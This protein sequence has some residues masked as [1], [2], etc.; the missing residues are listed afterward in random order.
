MSVLR[1][2]PVVAVA[3]LFAASLVQASPKTNLPRPSN[4]FLDPKDDPYNP[5][6]YIASNVLT[7]VA[8]SLIMFVALTET[9]M[10]RK[11][12]AKFM[13]SMVIGC[14]TFAF[15]LGTRFG[16]HVHPES[17]GLYICQYLFFG[18][19]SSTACAFI[20]SEYVLMGR[21]ARFLE[22][23]KHLMVS[24]R[25]ITTVFVSSDITTFLIQAAGGSVSISSN[26]L[27]IAKGTLHIF[28]AGLVLQ[29]ASF[30]T[31]TCIY[32]VFIHRVRTREPAIW[33]MDASDKKWHKDWRTLA[34][35]MVVSFAGIVIRSVYRVAELSQGFEGHLATSEPFFYGLDTLPLFIAVATYVVF[36]PGRYIGDGT[37]PAKANVI[38]KEASIDSGPVQQKVE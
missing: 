17:K 33:A 35:A 38:V 28:L 12:G 23:D 16:L 9:W 1:P 25:R 14:Y 19:S 18:S 37:P 27:S 13:L 2:L 5:L 3:L 6:K 7:A 4:P 24:P 11:W 8:F 21:L 32:F 29:L 34:G 26:T 22:C 15:G 10:I 30:F 36:W 20:A 31:F